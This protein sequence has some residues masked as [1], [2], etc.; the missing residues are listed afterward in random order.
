MPVVA[1]DA[2]AGVEVVEEDVRWRFLEE[3]F[4]SPASCDFLRNERT[5]QSANASAS[6][7]SLSGLSGEGRP[8]SS[9]LGFIYEGSLR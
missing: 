7:S 2:A 1:G 5:S 3:G 4:P 9:S 8:L 6:S